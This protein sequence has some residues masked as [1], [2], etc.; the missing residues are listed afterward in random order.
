MLLSPSTRPSLLVRIR[1][2]KDQQ[3]WSQFVE[4]YAPLV[5]AYARRQGL[6]DADAADLAQDVLRAVAR[7]AGKFV[8][9]AGQ[10]S[11]RGWLF[12]VTR[13]KLRTFHARRVRHVQGSGDSDIR[14]LLSQHAA[15]E[16]DSVVWDI[17]FK[18]RQFRWVADQIRTELHESTWLAFWKTAVEG[19]SGN[20]VA[21]GL[22]MTVAAVYLAKSRVMARLKARLR[23]LAED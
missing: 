8:Y 5:F 19:R 10:G 23:L 14:D 21:A 4:L 1:N 3:A 22:G 11:F 7:A 18:R 12:T 2:T 6:Q 17:E 13:N 20:E 9:D 16:D 15:P